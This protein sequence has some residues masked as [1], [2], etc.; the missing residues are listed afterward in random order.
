MLA[1]FS[2]SLGGGVGVG[3][4]YAKILEFWIWWAMSTN[5]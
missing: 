2:R 3:K 1:S 4:K 5:G